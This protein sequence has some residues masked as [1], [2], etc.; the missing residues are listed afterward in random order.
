MSGSTALLAEE[1][2]PAELLV[3]V[4][5][6]AVNALDVGEL[7]PIVAHLVEPPAAVTVAEGS[8]VV[9]RLDGALDVAGFLL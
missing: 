5:S 1:P 6:L 9:H 8:S 3:A 2:S 4:H 7:V